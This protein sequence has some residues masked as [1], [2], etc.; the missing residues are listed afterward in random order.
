M[1]CTEIVIQDHIVIRRGLD[2]VDGMLKKLED[3]QRIE[4]FD[5]TTMLKFLRL[6]G[7][8]YHQVMEEKVLFPALLLT[9][10]NNAALVQLVSEH[11]NERT[12]TDEIEEALMTRRGMAFF[13]SS[14]EL[15]ALLRKHCEREEAVIGDLA[16]HSLSKGQDDEIVAEFMTRRVQVESYANFSRLERRYP[17]KPSPEPLSPEHGLSQARGTPSYT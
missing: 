4:I 13:R 3:G 16:E 15:T 17:P 11:G 8:Q 7:D 5:A 1:K 6:F 12:L 10:P 2:I 9:S 14:H